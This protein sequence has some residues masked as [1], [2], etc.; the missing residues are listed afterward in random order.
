MDHVDEGSA[1]PEQDHDSEN[2]SDD[3]NVDE[4][5]THI[6]V[7]VLLCYKEEMDSFAHHFPHTPLANCLNPQHPDQYHFDTVPLD[8]FQ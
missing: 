7:G 2:G 4:V 1:L 6:S 8:I 3:Q 5:L